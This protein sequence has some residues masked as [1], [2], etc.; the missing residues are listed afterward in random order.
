MAKIVRIYNDTNAHYS[1]LAALHSTIN[2]K[3][4]GISSCRGTNGPRATSIDT[5]QTRPPDRPSVEVHKAP[6]HWLCQPNPFL[7]GTTNKHQIRTIAQFTESR[8]QPQCCLRFEI[9]Q[10]ERKGVYQCIPST[11]EIRQKLNPV[12]LA[13]VWGLRLQVERSMPLRYF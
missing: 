5:V 8:P 4:C 1:T 2:L 11:R 12:R 13:A 3:R 10:D 9:V 7:S 6:W